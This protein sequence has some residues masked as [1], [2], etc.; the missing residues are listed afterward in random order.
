MALLQSMA[1]LH[2]N[3]LGFDWAMSNL[4]SGL[5]SLSLLLISLSLKILGGG[6]KLSFKEGSTVLVCY[7]KR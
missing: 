2:V 5:K 1:T 4:G 6:R 3:Q 7:E